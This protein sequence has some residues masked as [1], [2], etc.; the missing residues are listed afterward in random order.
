MTHLWHAG[1]H[2]RLGHLPA[3]AGL[4]GQLRAVQLRRVQHRREHALGGHL[5]A[6]LSRRRVRASDLRDHRVAKLPRHPL[7]RQQRWDYTPLPCRLPRGDVQRGPHRRLHDGALLHV[8]PLLVQRPARLLVQHRRRD[9]LHHLSGRDAHGVL[10]RLLLPGRLV[11]ADRV[12]RW[13][14]LVAGRL[15]GGVVLLPRRPRAHA[16]A[17]GTAELRTC[18]VPRFAAAIPKTT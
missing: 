13:A 3:R 7:R 9:E 15:D 11:A 14:G 12:P 17:L 6:D 8:P 1:R 18:G 16:A 5:P 10:L 4:P 2:L